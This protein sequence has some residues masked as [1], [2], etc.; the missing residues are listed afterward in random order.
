MSSSPLK[1]S[2]L[3]RRFTELINQ[4]PS[5][6]PSAG[7]ETK[8]GSITPPL[9]TTTP[10][11]SASPLSIQTTSTECS[12]SPRSPRFT[13]DEQHRLPVTFLPFV[14][15]ETSFLKFD[16]F[17]LEQSTESDFDFTTSSESSNW[18]NLSDDAQTSSF[19]IPETMKKITTKSE[20]PKSV[21]IGW[22]CEDGFKPIGEFE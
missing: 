11:A 18:F 6:R 12:S 1:K 17:G 15:T 3:S 10:S 19:S 14:G 22:V 20:A 8:E 5:R 4:K 16:M 21:T 7:N 13:F 9:Q 2:S